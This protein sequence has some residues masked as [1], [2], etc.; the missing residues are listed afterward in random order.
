MADARNWA[1]TAMQKRPWREEFFQA[2]VHELSLLSLS[3]VSVLELGSGPGFL[4]A[5]V[6]QAL[7]VAKYV[8]LDFSPSMHTLAKEQ[9]GAMADR[10]TFLEGDFR[11]SD[12]NVGLPWFDAV[13]SMQA[14]HRTAPQAS[15]V[16][17]LPLR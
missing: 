1:A 7:P 17:T 15:R 13:L 14:I 2:I 11:R 4:A 12:W 6:L 16:R 8:A 5:C 3:A 10:V 9:L